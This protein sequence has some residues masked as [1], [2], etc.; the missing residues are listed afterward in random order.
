MRQILDTYGKRVKTRC[1]ICG[2]LLINKT[3]YGTF[4]DNMCELPTVTNMVKE[5]KRI[6]TD[7]SNYRQTNV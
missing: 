4:C 6:V 7:M 2:Q 5:I 1:S 3:K